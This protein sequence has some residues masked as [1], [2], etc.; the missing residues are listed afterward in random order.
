MGLDLV[1]VFVAD[2]EQQ[3]A[4]QDHQ[5]PDHYSHHPVGLVHGV[6]VLGG[7]VLILFKLNDLED[8]KFVNQ[9]KFGTIIPEI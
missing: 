7:R 8:F 9:E 2:K 3:R 4:A 5:E 6:L 1:V